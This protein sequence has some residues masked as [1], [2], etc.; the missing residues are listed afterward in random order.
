M[1][2]GTQYELGCAG[3]GWSK[4][5]L[6]CLRNMRLKVL[7]HVSR[8]SCAKILIMLL[9]AR[10]K[11]AL[12]VEAEAAGGPVDAT[13]NRELLLYR[14]DVGLRS[15]NLGELCNNVLTHVEGFLTGAFEC[16]PEWT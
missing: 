9:A 6:V 16:L 15:S 14:G 7:G 3:G 5:K 10:C 13:C 8:K 11:M 4:Y 12:F 1:V 2:A